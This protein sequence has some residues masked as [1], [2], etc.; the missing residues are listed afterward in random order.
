MK[1][2]FQILHTNRGNKFKNKVIDGLLSIFIIK[3]SLSKKGYPYDN[4]I[5]KATFK[6]I[7]TEFAF[8]RKFNNLEQLEL[9]LFNY[10]NWYNN[11]RINVSLGYNTPVNYRQMVSEKKCLK[12]Y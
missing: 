5:A 3:R 1:K 7:K 11:H 12:K 2:E 6:L 10:I 8:N 4:A 9:E